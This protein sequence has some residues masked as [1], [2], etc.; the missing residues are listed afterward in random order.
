DESLVR[1]A[2]VLTKARD[3]GAEIGTVEL[4]GG[5]NLAGEKAFAERAERDEANAEF[6]ESRHHRFFGFTPEERV[7]ALQ[8]CDGLYGMSTTDRFAPA[9]ERPK[10]LTLPSWIR[11][12]TAPAV[13]SIGVLG[14]TRCW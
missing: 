12:F 8:G 3:D 1:F 10:C 5:I 14:S 2:I 7:F 13:S 9:S 6:R 4:R 11:S